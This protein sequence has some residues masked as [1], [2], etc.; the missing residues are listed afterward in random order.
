MCSGE[1]ILPVL[2]TLEDCYSTVRRY[3]LK[4]KLSDSTPRV[5]HGREEDGQKRHFEHEREHEV[6]ELADAEAEQE[7]EH[8]HQH[9][10]EREHKIVNS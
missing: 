6:Q 7:P 9:E 2:Y 4:R 3:R 1:S 5:V 10:G 8:E